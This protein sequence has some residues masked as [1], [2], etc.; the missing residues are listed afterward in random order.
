M[1]GINAKGILHNNQSR[2]IYTG[3]VITLLTSRAS[4]SSRRKVRPSTSLDLDWNHI[5][6]HSFSQMQDSV[7]GMLEISW[8]PT[9]SPFSVRSDNNQN[10]SIHNIHNCDDIHNEKEEETKQPIVLPFTLE[11]TFLPVTSVSDFAR[12]CHSRK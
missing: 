5:V 1:K 8:S 2:L 7:D 4:M 6:P 9:Q 3:I 11:E 12:H 10:N